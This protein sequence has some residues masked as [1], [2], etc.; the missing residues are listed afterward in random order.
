MSSAEGT[1]DK[2]QGLLAMPEPPVAEKSP[3]WWF[4]TGVRDE[5]APSHLGTVEPPDKGAVGVC[6]SGGGICWP[7]LVSRCRR[8]G[9]AMAARAAAPS[10]STT[11]CGVPLGTQSPYQVEM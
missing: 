8:A 2:D 10:L 7:R 1:L 6:C 3:W 5:P 9:S 4:L 11:S